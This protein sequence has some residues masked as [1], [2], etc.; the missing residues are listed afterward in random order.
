M[1]RPPT[2]DS[3]NYAYWRYANLRFRG[4]LLWMLPWGTHIWFVGRF[5]PH[6][7]SSCV[8]I[9]VFSFAP[10]ALACLPGGRIASLNGVNI[11]HFFEHCGTYG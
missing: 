4:E 2:T 7:N 3:K 9:V 6:V 11:A 10:F 1:R 8:H 5:L